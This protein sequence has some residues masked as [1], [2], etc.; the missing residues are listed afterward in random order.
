MSS[1]HI[2]YSMT[3]GRPGTPSRLQVQAYLEASP[4]QHS[5]APRA[6]IGALGHTYALS[7]VFIQ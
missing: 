1:S 2:I 3:Q 6:G 5:D 7:T 4:Q